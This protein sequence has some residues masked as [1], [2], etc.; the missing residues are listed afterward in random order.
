MHYETLLPSVFRPP[1]YEEGIES[2]LFHEFLLEC[3]KYLAPNESVFH[4]LCFMQH[5]GLPTRL[6]DW[7]RNILVA[8]YFATD[9]SGSF[10]NKDGEIFSFN[11]F[12]LNQFSGATGH[13]MLPS[14]C[15][16][17]VRSLLA[18]G[19]ETDDKETFRNRVLACGCQFNGEISFDDLY[20]SLF[21][22][23]NTRLRADICAPIAVIPPVIDERLRLQ[24]SV[25]TI[26]GGLILNRNSEARPMDLL[27]WRHAET[28][29]MVVKKFI[30]PASVKTKLRT[31]LEQVGV[32]YATL[33]PGIDSIAHLIK[34][35]Y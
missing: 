22:S 32:S 5:H 29:E 15:P 20:D 25:F 4:R 16:V 9:T 1:Y 21:N 2:S 10:I 26:S 27:N 11:P 7:T 8:T 35:K 13:L 17:M 24:Q 33:F 19:I 34:S 18:E 23:M 31:E 3:H 6:L 12:Y 28:N 30:V 14:T